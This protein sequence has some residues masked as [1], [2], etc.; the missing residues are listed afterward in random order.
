[1]TVAPEPKV[2]PLTTTI[3]E[4]PAAS[5]NTVGSRV[6]VP[7]AAYAGCAAKERIAIAL[8]IIAILINTVSIFLLLGLYIILNLQP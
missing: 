3:V 2:P 6:I 4:E 1:L 8:K 7:E 5:V